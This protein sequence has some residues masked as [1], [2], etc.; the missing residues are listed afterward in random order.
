MAAR[1]ENRGPM[2]PGNEAGATRPLDCTCLERG[3]SGHIL[4]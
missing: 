1:T 3:Q 4:I 2:G